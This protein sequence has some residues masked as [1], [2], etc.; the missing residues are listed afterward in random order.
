V[1]G[2]ISN[3]RPYRDSQIYPLRAFSAFWLT[4]AKPVSRKMANTCVI[5]TLSAGAQ[6]WATRP[7]CLADAGSGQLS[8]T[9]LRGTSFWL[10]AIKQSASGQAW[11][12]GSGVIEGIEFRGCEAIR[13]MASPERMNGISSTGQEFFHGIRQAIQDVLILVLA[14]IGTVQKQVYT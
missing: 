8:Q 12:W 6:G 7:E 14:V 9:L 1:R 11:G 2:A 4:A 3:G 10:T 13:R 5:R